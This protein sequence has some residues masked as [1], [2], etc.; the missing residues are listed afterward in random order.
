MAA[1]HNFILD[2]TVVLGASALGGYVASR[3][4][5]PVLLGYLASGFIVG[6]FGFQLLTEVE[7]IKPLAEI[8]VAFLLFALG[9][10]FSLAELKRVKEIAIQGSLLQIGLTLS[11]VAIATSLLGWA[12]GWNQAVFLGSILSL[13]STAVV[14][15]TLTE[16][17]EVNTLHGQVMLAILIAQDLALGL[18]LAILPALDNPENL[19]PT[20]GGAL[21]KALIF[22]GLAIAFGKWVVPP[23]IKSVART[24]SSELFLLTTIALCL[25]VALVT[26]AL[27]LSIE[28]GAFVA[29]LMMSE[30]D[31]ADQALAKILPL[32]DTFASLFFA[33]IGMLID[34][35][36]LLDNFGIILALVI[37]V[38]LGKAL[39]ILPTVLNFGYSFKTATIA[40]LGLNQIG[41]FSFVLAL[42]GFDLGLLSEEKY[43]LILGTTAITLV[44]TPLGI[45]SAPRLVDWFGSIPALANIL[46]RFQQVKEL[47]LPET[48]DNH[49]V[50]AGYG[51][52]GEA[53]A[54][55]MHN[56]GYPLL[57]VENS[58]AAIQRLRQKNIPY[59]FGDADSE[60]VLEK[61]HLEKAKALAIALPDPASTRLLLKRALEFAPNLDV[62]A[63]SHNNSEIDVLTQL[64]AQEVV[65][66]EFEAALEMGA[67]LLSTLGESQWAIQSAIQ[68]IH[69]E[70]YQSVR[71]D[72]MV[73]I[74]QKWIADAT[75]SLHHEW[76][77]V[78]QTSSLDW[79]TLT[80]TDI[81]HL[82]GV[83]VMAIQQGDD[84]LYYPKKQITLRS[85]DQ[86]L[87]VGEPDEIN[88]FRDLVEGRCLLAEGVSHWLILSDRSALVN[89][90]PNQIWY[91]YQ[92]A[93]Q[94]I[95]RH[96]KL[97]HPV[98]GAMHLEIEDCLLLRADGDRLQQVIGLL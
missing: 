74:Q 6:P 66:P 13:S 20:L 8:G 51:R 28:M 88:A 67:H 95:R 22:F 42:K 46:R 55:I 54:R 43:F 85:G 11:L 29:G 76:V 35:R 56:R 49:V 89:L 82:T 33:S 21:L 17:G 52:V 30:I 10:E 41:E 25:G 92:V 7:Q 65:Q 94:A 87:V 57:V 93:I 70:R 98:D 4:R 14:L 84:L 91:Q 36:I 3:L 15:K 2:L 75:E 61:T 59:I 86:L 69:Q 16:R 63:R 24:E 64:G 38:M 32:R 44:L 58:E 48:M 90:T 18:M 26:A 40:A 5:Q 39:I 47:S 96:G 37:L 97:Y 81:R 79:M 34:P 80:A 27:G 83:T 53:I 73:S 77:V 72:S 71:P 78:D 19:W 62:V 12:E 9:V 60:L 31:Y 45:R 68:T 50:L 1:D 23:A